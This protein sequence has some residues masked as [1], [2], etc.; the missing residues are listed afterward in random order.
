MTIWPAGSEAIA[1]GVA[2]IEG[3]AASTLRVALAKLRQS[4]EL[5]HAA[6]NR[7]PARMTVPPII[8]FSLVTYSDQTELD[9]AAAGICWRLPLGTRPRVRIWGD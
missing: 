4:V 7:R 9:N 3:I 1:S 5:I 6:I 2:Q 8:E